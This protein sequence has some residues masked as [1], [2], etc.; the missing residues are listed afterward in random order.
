MAY[1][2]KNGLIEGFG[3]DS[4]PLDKARKQPVQKRAQ[5]RGVKLRALR[6]KRL[7]HGDLFS[8]RVKPDKV[9]PHQLQPRQVGACETPA[10]PKVGPDAM[11]KHFRYGALSFFSCYR[12]GFG[13]FKPM[14]ARLVVLQQ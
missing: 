12:A 6:Q 5:P 7:K 3:L 8:K 10:A 13:L 1:T 14:A 2:I 4:K 11:R 9:K